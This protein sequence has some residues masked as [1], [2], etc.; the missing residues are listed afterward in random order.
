MVEIL[1]TFHTFDVN[2]KHMQKKLLNQI[3][4]KYY[5]G[6]RGKLIREKVFLL[7]MNIVFTGLCFAQN[8][9]VFENN[10]KNRAL[11]DYGDPNSLVSLLVQNQ[12]KINEYLR[13][14]YYDNGFSNSAS[15]NVFSSGLQFIRI[16]GQPIEIPLAESQNNVILVKSGKSFDTWYDSLLNNPNVPRTIDNLS[17]YEQIERMDKEMLRSSW[18]KGKDGSVLCYPDIIEPKYSIANINLI[19]VDSTYIY[20]AQKSIFENKHIV[21]L[22]LPMRL[23]HDFDRVDFIP[24]EISKVIYSK[25]REFQIKK[26]E[27]E[28]N[29]E[30]PEFA[31]IPYET[32]TTDGM[33]ELFSTLYESEYNRL[34][35]T[36][37][38]KNIV[39]GRPIEV[40]SWE[41]QMSMNLVRSGKS[42]D[43]WYDSLLHDPNV[44]RSTEGISDYDDLERM[45]K[46]ML[47]SAWNKSVEGM[48]LIGPDGEAVYWIEIPKFSMYLKQSIK[49]KDDTLMNS[50][51]DANERVIKSIL[52]TEKLEATSGFSEFY[53]WLLPSVIMAFGSEYDGYLSLEIQKLLEEEL[54]D[55]QIEL[56]PVWEKTLDNKKGRYKSNDD[57]KKIINCNAVDNNG[58]YFRED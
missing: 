9:A 17:D 1:K 12:N 37:G 34:L 33:G 14:E 32:E 41:S 24:E 13:D 42:F 53:N 21:C 39:R 11:F 49:S 52:I 25:L 16:K 40:Y 5:T 4:N 22:K 36:N 38:I 6:I 19:I 3:F 50:K 46:E 28:Y 10:K 58:I 23:I 56:H 30:F 7:L 8:F 20:F 47:R 31:L 55:L 43:I 18:N 44:P 48:E 51:E 2:G 54:K 57:I 35:K 26:K 29:T 27:L 15:D 45:D